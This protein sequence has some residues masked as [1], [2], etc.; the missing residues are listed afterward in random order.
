MSKTPK[1][2]GLI[3]SYINERIG[4]TITPAQITEAVQCTAPTTYAFIKNNPQRFE[5]LSAGQYRILSSSASTQIA[6]DIN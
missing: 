2:A 6:G 4:Q 3:E 1:Y 5:K